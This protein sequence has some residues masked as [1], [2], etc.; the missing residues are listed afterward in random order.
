M[1]LVV[2]WHVNMHSEE[3]GGSPGKVL[4]VFA[5]ESLV[6]SAGTFEKPTLVS[7]EM[8]SFEQRRSV[9]HW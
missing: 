5:S 4:H 1:R 9:E 7:F 6:S 8:R 3:S 2:G